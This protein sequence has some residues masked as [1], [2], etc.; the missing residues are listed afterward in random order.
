MSKNS[1]INCQ[2]KN[3]GEVNLFEMS[4]EINNPSSGGSSRQNSVTIQAST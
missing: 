3:D 2:V 1:P 4:V